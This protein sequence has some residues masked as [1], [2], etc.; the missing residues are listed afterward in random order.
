MNSAA[1]HYHYGAKPALLE[2]VVDH[3]LAPLLEE[4]AKRREQLS[5]HGGGAP[6]PA[7]EIVRAILEPMAALHRAPGH[8][9]A[10]LGRLMAWLW[11]ERDVHA[12]PRALDESLARFAELACRGRDDLEPTEAFERLEYATGAAARVFHGDR[13]PRGE[14]I[15]ARLERLVQFLAAGLA[16]P[17]R[18]PA[19]DPR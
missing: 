5:A 13:E 3:R 9:Q 19:Q 10:P 16:S 15:E 4:H 6:I 12:P 11:V 1:I 17:G 18:G 14:A 7:E 8:V 2:A